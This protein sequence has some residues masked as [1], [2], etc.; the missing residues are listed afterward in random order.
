MKTILRVLRFFGL[1]VLPFI[2]TALLLSMGFAYWCAASASGTRWLL[3]TVATQL[4]GIAQGVHG[5]LRDGAYVEGLSLVLPGADV[6]VVGLHLKILWPELLERRVRID[7][8]S[9]LRIDV[10]LHPAPDEATEPDS[11]FQMPALPVDIQIDRLALGGLGL[12]VG[13]EA[14]PVELLSVSTALTLDRHAA[15]VRLDQLQAAWGQ[16]L[17]SLDGRLGVNGLASPWP[18]V[19]DLHGF[20]QDRSADSPLCLRRALGARAAAGEPGP[21][22]ECRI[23][24]GL[25]VEGSLDSLTAALRAEGEGLTLKAD[26]DVFPGQPFPV[27]RAQASASFPDG[28]EVSLQVEP[29]AAEGGGRTL[30]AQFAMRGF[31][32]RPWLP[33]ELGAS[34]LSVQG[35][36]RVDLDASHA[37]R[38]LSL[39]LGVDPKSRWNGQPLSG[40]IAVDRVGRRSGPLFD[41]AAAGGFDVGGLAVSGLDA[42]VTLGRDRVRMRGEFSLERMAL[43]LRADL[44][45]LAALWPD[46][47]GGARLHATLEGSAARQRLM[48]EAGYNPE[49]AKEGVLGRAPIDA[50]LRLDGGWVEDQGWRGAL[51]ALDVSHAGLS[52]RSETAVP[53]ELDT[54]SWA[55]KVGAARLAV[56]LDGENLLRLD[57]AASSGS[58]RQWSS[59]GH[60]D[61]LVVTPGRIEQLQGWLARGAREEGGVRTALSAQARDSRLEA[62]LDWSLSY[63]DALAGDI[64]LARTGGDLVVPGDVPIEL[65]LREAALDVAIRRRAPGLSQIE[66]DLQVATTRMGSMRIR[67]GSPLHASAGGGLGIDPKDPKTVRIEAV[68]EDLA[69][70]NLFLQGG[71]EVGGTIHADIQGRSLPDGR[72][73]LSGPLRGEH[74]TL[75]SVDQGVRLLDGTLQAHFDGERVT[76]DALRFP[77]VRRVTPKE[78]RTATW[79]AEEPDAQNGSLTLSGE[80]DLFRQGGGLDIAF[81][82]YPIL[83]RADRYAM[84]S[85]AL[86]I[87][88]VLP[89]LAI[90][91]RIAADAG[92]FD[93]DMLSNIPSLDGDVVILEPGKKAPAPE[94]SS[95]LLD[96]DLD[97]AVDLGLRFYLTGY[98]V[99][100]G[101]VGEIKLRMAAGKLTGIGELRTRG[102]SLDAYGQHLQLRRG[103]V[104][105]QG[106]ITNPVIG[107]E[108]LRTDAAVRAGVR[109]AGTARRPRIDLV[110]YPDVSETEKLTWLLLGHGPDESGG[111]MALLF[112]V[113]SSFLS[114]GE[115]FYQRFG[116]DEL[117]MRSGELGSTGSILPIQSVVSSQDTS[118]ASDIEQRFILAGKT[119]SSGLRA[120]LEQALSQTGTV[121]R[122]SYRLMRGLRAELTVGTVNG[123]AL[124]YRWFSMD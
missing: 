123:L 2:V 36:T 25:H 81:H 86:R 21:E 70:V 43:E 50:R 118:G 45:A 20:A 110:S 96:I 12:T 58:G 62:R 67:A 38:A 117:S 94:D 111:D 24:L 31:D 61:P 65:G 103:T 95:P 69:W 22:P 91:G 1:W 32:L 55:W 124:V 49:D 68:S 80:W 34:L 52:L 57:H 88:S 63:D 54:P 87:D 19:L 74:I 72:W 107:I 4:D 5:T 104:T 120:S 77:A 85:G 6:R 26:A 112:S 89:R 64:R 108:A 121:A 119:L 83:Q 17:L 42:D 73:S 66:A 102:G 99:N 53:L 33:E 59:R 35:Q 39:K 84:I 105:F 122:L 47:P 90:R 76:L 11:P 98:G 14:P 79:I 29:Q 30:A 93:L 13:G 75:L 37:V 106:D 15:S 78:W 101:L 114:G 51:A 44:P 9:A 97:L 92:W 60:I 48:L 18:L 8:V 71:L 56:G 23:V 28:S 3:R 116:L 41:A 46:L 7:D 109:V 10:A 113:G 82:R 27:G 100:S 115:P 40:A 16:M